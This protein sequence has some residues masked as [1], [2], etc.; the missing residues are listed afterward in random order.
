MQL[1]LLYYYESQMKHID[2]ETLIADVMTALPLTV[3][4]S[5]PVKRAK[6]IL[7]DNNFKHLPVMTGGVLRGILTDRDLKLAYATAENKTELDATPVEQVCVTEPTTV[8]KDAT[9]LEALEKILQKDIGSVI[10][11]EHGVPVGIF[12]RKDCAVVLKKII[13]AK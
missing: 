12:T 2:R 9:L 7:Y 3:D 6:Q 10:V 1:T 13:T 5:K 11:V 4:G 8:S